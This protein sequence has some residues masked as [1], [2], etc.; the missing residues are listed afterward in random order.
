[1]Q[2]EKLQY[3]RM[4][5]ERMKRRSVYIDKVYKK[6]NRCKDAKQL[7]T[8]FE[9]YV[10]AKNISSHSSGILVKYNSQTFV[11]VGVLCF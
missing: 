6:K 3:V 7:I 10:K 1:M 9:N 5:L 11:Q 2:K 4:H 8:L